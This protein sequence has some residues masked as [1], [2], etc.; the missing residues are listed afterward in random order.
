MAQ[1][2]K[3]ICSRL[4]K[5]NAPF[6]TRLPSFQNRLNIDFKNMMNKLNGEV[7]VAWMEAKD[8]RTSKVLIINSLNGI[9]AWIKTF[10]ALSEKVSMDTIFYEK[11]SGYEIRELPVHRFPEK[12]FY[13]LISGFNTSYYTSAGKTLFIGE[14]LDELKKY[15]DDIDKEDTWGKS[16][17]QNQYLESTS[18]RIKRKLVYK[19]APTLECVGNIFATTLEKICKGKS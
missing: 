7:G 9:D 11:Y 4:I 10:D 19:Y 12:I 1:I 5:D 6:V 14:D 2:F 15:L 18:A 13:P 8:Q 3:L 16:V 17:A